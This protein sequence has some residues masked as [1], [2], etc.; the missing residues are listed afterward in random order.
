MKKFDGWIEFKT[1]P[2]NKGKVAI[3]LFL[4]DEQKQLAAPRFDFEALYK[5]YPRHEGKSIGLRRCRS[6]IETQKQYDDLSRAIDVYR[7]RC[8][9]EGYDKSFIKQFSS[10]MTDW[11]DW[12]EYQPERTDSSDLFNQP[13]WN[14]EDDSPAE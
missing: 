12:L 10:F 8:Q 13:A 4:D 5:K 2:M 6:Q 7:E 1:N 14:I 9:R 11:R 3:S